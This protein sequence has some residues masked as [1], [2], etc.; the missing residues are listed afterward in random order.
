MKHIRIGS[1]AG[2]AGD[3]L[4]P[5][6]EL[7][8]KGNLDYIGF[9]CLAER[10]IAL[11]Q[12]EK[13]KDQDKGYNPLLEYR[14]E[15]V[16][17]MAW[18]NKVKVIT[19]MGA[20]NPISAAKKCLA[21]AKAH[22]CYGMKIAAV[23]GDDVL[24]KLNAYQNTEIW[25]THRPLKELQGTIVSA[26]AYL[27]AE[28]IIQALSDG[29]DVIIT[30]R[31]SDPSL[32]MAPILYEFGWKE[33]DWEKMGKATQVG[34]LLE[35]AGQVCGGYYAD[36]GKKDVPDLARIGFPI[37]EV[38]E[39]G[40]IFITKVE[41][42]G[43]IVTVDTCTE[44]MLYEV[45]DPCSYLTPDVTADF[46]SVSF[47]QA[48]PDRVEALGASGGP[49]PDKLK[50]SIG[51]KDCYIGEGEISYGGA[52]CYARALLA[53]EILQERITN[54]RKLPV[55]ELKIDLI[56][57][58]ALYRYEEHDLPFSPHEIRV[59]AAA[60]TK[61]PETAAQIGEEVESLY[62]NGPA[63][64]GGAVKKV[65]EVLSVASM[66]IRREDAVPKITI[67]EVSE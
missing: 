67:L 27:G 63:G 51:Y 40:K 48:G 21:I 39:D 15:Q 55:D 29:A 32:F 34:H 60:R 66:L 7:I 20:A 54:I 65:T 35:C 53:R 25:E 37:A 22:G 19:N 14:M 49:R 52:N 59:R 42:S 61:D 24:E 10:T 8:E 45:Q 18:K 57:V 3:R 16:L 41:G 2:F 56:G 44:Q 13:A 28:G 38:T 9:E 33:E 12:Q 62:T 5:A 31:V 30:G 17:P 50:V 23:T 64:G 26:N 43:G 1:G 36:P 46:S 11:A 6:L 4:E 58:N 47:V